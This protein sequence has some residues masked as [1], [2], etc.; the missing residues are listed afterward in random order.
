MLFKKKNNI[1]FKIIAN[2]VYVSF[3]EVFIN[4]YIFNKIIKKKDRTLTI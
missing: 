3:N 1:N 4:K 2:I